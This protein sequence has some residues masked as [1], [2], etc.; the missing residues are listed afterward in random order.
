MSD[1][2]TEYSNGVTKRK[3]LA[4]MDLE[5]A[6]KIQDGYLYSSSCCMF[7]LFKY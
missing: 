3:D 1:A 2:K 6:G 5:L 7:R 4:Q